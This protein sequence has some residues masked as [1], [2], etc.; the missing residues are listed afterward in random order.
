MGDWKTAATQSAV[1]VA[2]WCL[3]MP[4]ATLL[5]IWF[6]AMALT[7]FEKP[8]GILTALGVAWVWHMG[9]KVKRDNWFDA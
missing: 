6:T 4:F 7:E 9:R 2:F 5:S 3:F 8:W 1:T